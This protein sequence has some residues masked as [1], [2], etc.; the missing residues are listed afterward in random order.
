M[1]KALA[2]TRVV[3]GASILAL[4][5]WFPAIA[6]AQVGHVHQQPKAEAS[7]SARMADM[8]DHAM[9]DAMDENMMKHMNLTPSRAATHD[10]TLRAQQLVAELRR[11]IAKYQDTS[12]A[13]ADGYQMFLPNV[14]TQHVYHFTNYRRAFKEAFR[15]DPAE[16]T[17]ILYQRAADGKL[18]LVGAMYT[19]PKR[20]SLDRLNDRV[21]L[22]IAHWHQHVNWCLPKKGEQARF[23]ETKNGSPVFGP[24]SPIATKADCDAVNGDFHPSLFGW[25]VHANVF[26]GD[27]TDLGAVFADDHGAHE[28]AHAHP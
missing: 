19:M 22:S 25:M 27:P 1:R 15:F 6:T 16:P 4:G 8:A 5:S 20:A 21:P 24:E 10:D 28:S 23:L 3:L 17:S 11:A 7:D 13:V 14:K 18:H 2:V 26:A 12:A 9:G